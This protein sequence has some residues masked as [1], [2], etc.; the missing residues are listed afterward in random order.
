MEKRT[1]AR[2]KL[3]QQLVRGGNML[4]IGSRTNLGS[5]RI[6]RAS[7]GTARPTAVSAR[8]AAAELRRGH[9]AAAS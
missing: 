3:L 5:A 2:A 9:C 7:C 8:A 4:T 1:M 6:A